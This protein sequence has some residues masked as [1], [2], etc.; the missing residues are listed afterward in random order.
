MVLTEPASPAGNDD[1][2]LTIYC[3]RSKGPIDLVN[4]EPSRKRLRTIIIRPS[5]FAP[6]GNRPPDL[7]HFI[8][9]SEGN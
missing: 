2:D 5:D 1:M 7:K 8:K 4:V 6:H 9:A 3:D